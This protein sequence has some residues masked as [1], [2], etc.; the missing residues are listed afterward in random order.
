MTSDSIDKSV[1]RF[2]TDIFFGSKPNTPYSTMDFVHLLLD[3]VEH[4]D[5]VN[6]TSMRL[7][8]PT[9]ETLF[10]RLEK[11]DQEQLFA[12]FASQLIV[13]GH[14]IVRLVRNREV[15]LAF[16]TTDEPFYGKVEGLWI[17]PYCEA[18]GSTGCFKFLTVSAVDRQNRLILGVLPVPVGADMV[19]LI[20]RLLLQARQIINP[21]L[22]LFDRGF[23]SYELVQKLRYQLFW[24]KPAWTT[25]QFK[26]MK[27][28]EIREVNRVG[29]YSK[30]KTKHKVKLRFVLIK[31]YRR[32]AKSKAFNWVFC[33][34]TRQ[35]SKQSYIDKYRMRWG[36]ETI[37]RVLDNAQIKTTTKNVLIRYFLVLICCLVYNLW[38]L[39]I[40]IDGTISLK[41][42][43]VAIIK[44]LPLPKQR[45]IN[46]PN[47]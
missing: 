44:L 9:G 19:A 29:T 22:C 10:K 7:G 34:N 12:A 30:H 24:K 8:G 23:D 26:I 45:P 46:V 3:A 32:F 21:R 37:F 33:T 2:L 36:I 1:K 6:N 42:F 14:Q 25:N 31:S 40:V 20:E 38:K 39:A 5:F 16:D 13:T 4:Q 18:K 11:V 35:K 17:H 27:R 41:N 15:A 47:G 43:V 28:N